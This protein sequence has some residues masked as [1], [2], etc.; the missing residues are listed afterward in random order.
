[1][2][3]INT[4]LCPRE[5]ILGIFAH[6]LF[7]SIPFQEEFYR[8]GKGIVADLWSTNYSEMKSIVLAIPPLPEQSAI[9][10]VLDRETAKI[11]ALVAEQEKLIELLKEKRQA[12]ISHAVTKG[13]DPNVPMKDSGVEWLGEVPSHWEIKRIKHL[14]E[15]FN[16]LTYNP[17]EISDD[18]TGTL[19]LRSS[20][21]QNGIISL[22]DNVYVTANIPEKL[23]VKTGDILICSRNGSRALIGKNAI[24]NEDVSGSTFG[25][26]M[27]VFRSKIYR[28]IRYILN[29]ELFT[30]QSSAFLTSTINQLT[31]QNFNG[32]EVPVPPSDEQSTIAT[33]LDYETERI[34]ALVTESQRAIDL[35]K[36]R[37]AALISA[38]VTG[39]IDVRGLV[40]A[41]Q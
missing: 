40:E 5:D 15:A 9:A 37:R 33:F 20:N 1:M 31:V 10:T 4:V 39:K 22:E 36:E 28:Y 16:G 24:I 41:T 2:S 25:V 14:G 34:D 19:V 7:R 3:L 8:Y 12:V 38:A 21:V 6:H 13:L 27:M 32:F 30:F 17:S 29:S 18:S 23:R 35:L 11:D 26:F